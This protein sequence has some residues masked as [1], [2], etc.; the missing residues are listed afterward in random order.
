MRI[1]DDIKLDY[2]DVLIRPKRS[3]ARSRKEVK[4]ERT[5]RFKHSSIELDC[6]PIIGANMD[7]VGTVKMAEKLQQVYKALT[8][9]TKSE[10]DKNERYP[11]NFGIPIGFN[12]DITSTFKT[13]NDRLLSIF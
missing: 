11:L 3:E 12:D 13:I 9:L 6:L 10:H 5:F 7:G 1:E 2:S 4:L 8:F